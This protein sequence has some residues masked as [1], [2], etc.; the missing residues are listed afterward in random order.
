M[1]EFFSFHPDGSLKWKCTDIEGPFASSVFSLDGHIVAI[2]KNGLVYVLNPQDGRTV[3]PP[4]ELPGQSPE[5]TYNISSFPG[6]WEGMII[7]SD[8]IA[9][10]AFNALMGYQFKI[11]NTPAVNPVN[12]RIY[13]VGTV[14]SD[15]SSD[16][17]ST[18][19][20]RFYGLDFIPDRN[21]YQGKLRLAFQTK[22]GP[23]SGAS[24]A[25][26]PDGSHIYTLDGL[27]TLY[28][29]NKEG[30]KIWT[31]R[32][33]GAPASP[34]IGPDGM[35][36]SVGG[37]RLHAVKDLGDSGTILW[38][39]DFSDTLIKRLYNFLPSSIEN[40]P[41]QKITLA[42]RCNSVVS[43][44]KNHLYLTLAVGCE[45]MSEEVNRPLFLPARC[46]LVV[47]SPPNTKRSQAI[48]NSI[49]E[50]PDTTEGII[51]LDNDGRVFCTHASIASSIAYSMCRKM[52]FPFR[53]PIGGVSVLGPENPQDLIYYRLKW[54]LDLITTSFDGN[55]FNSHFTI[56]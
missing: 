48:I 35:I 34:A 37:S 39:K 25:V 40:C 54:A 45:I 15:A 9:G 4:L 1:D 20:G 38:H 26:S 3:A 46:F 36:Y 6:L 8:E 7:S 19:Q 5:I 41:C 29:F 28:A 31:L 32:I 33:N 10:E 47:L 30:E 50:L 21:N 27:G 55:I 49:I 17:P 16:T 14:Q 56:F 44:S 52:G 11:T 2:N 42:V 22:M 24:P 53:K 12:G 43:V 13:I 51:T 23:G 18:L